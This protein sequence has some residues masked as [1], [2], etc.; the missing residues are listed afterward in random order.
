MTNK[1]MPQSELN[2]LENLFN[3]FKELK[4]THNKTPLTPEMLKEA[5]DLEQ[6]HIA[7]YL[8]LLHDL[9]KSL[10]AIKDLINM[11]EE[12]FVKIVTKDGTLSLD[13]VKANIMMKMFLDMI[14]EN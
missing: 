4:E 3:C 2:N 7:L 14:G 1:V 13:E 9:T 12:D 6:I 10:G 5:T 11:P 8:D